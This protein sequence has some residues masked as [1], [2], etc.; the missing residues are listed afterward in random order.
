MNTELYGIENTTVFG[1]YREPS[2]NLSHGFIYDGA[3]FTTIDYPLAANTEIH[4]MTRELD[5]ED[6]VSFGSTRVGQLGASVT[7]NVADAPSGARLDAWIDFDRDGTWGGPLE[8][9]ANNVSVID[10]GSIL[11][12]DVPSTAADGATIARFRLST[13][14]NLGIRGVASDGEV[15]DHV[16]TLISPAAA[17]GD[18][19]VQTAISTTANGA[20]SVFAADM[21]RDGDTD[22]LSASIDDDKI[23]WYE[24]DGSQNFIPRTITTSANRAISV[25]AADVDGDGD[26]DA[27][28]AS[29]G[30]GRIAWY[31]N[32]GSQNFIARTVSNA[33]NGAYS[34][35]A[36][37]VDGDGDTDVLSAAVIDA[38]I[39]WYENDGN[40]NFTQRTIFANTSNGATSV[41]AADVDGDGDLDVLSA[42]LAGDK[43]V[44]YE[45][46]GSQNFTPRIISTSANGA[47]SVFA[48]DVDR[49]GDTDV[50][51]A[52][53]SDGRIAWY[54][55]DGD[56]NF[57]A[58]TISNTA[59][60]ARSVFA[61]DLDGDG[62]TDVL[63]ASISDDKIAWYEND[64]S[65]NFATRIITTNA[66]VAL[67]VFAADVDGDGDLDVLSASEFDDKIAWYENAGIVVDGDFND[68]GV[69]DCLDINALTGAVSTGGSVAEFDLNRDSVLS[70]AD[71]ALWRAEAGRVNLG[72]GRVYL[73]GDANLDSVVDVSD[74]GIWN[75]HK[76]TSNLN[77][78]DGNFNADNAIDVSD[79]NLW[80]SNKFT[81]SDGA[82]RS[83][84]DIRF[85]ITANPVRPVWAMPSPCR[86]TNNISPKEVESMIPR[87]PTPLSSL[88]IRSRS[89]EKTSYLIETNRRQTL[90]RD[91]RVD[92]VAREW[93]NGR[94]TEIDI[95][96][97][98][99]ASARA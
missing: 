19:K 95:I 6:G 84:A 82:G 22:V 15:E 10:G 40:Q 49:D 7:V 61:A 50:L 85:V 11:T 77:W 97:A 42:S 76:F 26:T 5:D 23:A 83:S 99:W 18:F 58:Q 60:G 93:H 78:C 12:F 35:F 57:I 36:A 33:T 54:E 89:T 46:G 74:F 32:D 38:R 47:I 52:S 21:D 41:F 45:N 92:L 51:S 70:L 59:N 96:M 9:I 1:A 65:Q 25:F 3:T 17:L 66:D 88:P 39:A 56:Q 2:T 98:S 16:I 27:L 24:N 75:G 13:A 71:V 20:A 4:G 63:S 14:G 43:V 29:Y 8:Q 37:D 44:W 67:S 28:S 81:S 80:N 79:F 53:I 48:A 87:P 90:R 86:W 72:V 30:D 62:D 64:G 73:P 31:E 69:Y 68:D 55:N 34:V 91:I 94:S